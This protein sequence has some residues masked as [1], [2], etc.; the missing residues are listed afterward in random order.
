MGNKDDN[1]NNQ[2]T[3]LEQEIVRPTSGTVQTVI[4]EEMIIQIRNDTINK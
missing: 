4:Y 3:D 1:I 2:S